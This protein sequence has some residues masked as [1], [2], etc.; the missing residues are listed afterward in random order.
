MAMFDVE[1]LAD[2]FWKDG[3]LYFPRFFETAQMTHLDAI[4]LE[5]FGHMP[6]WAHDDEFIEKSGAEIVPWFPQKEGITDFDIIEADDRLKAVTRAVLGDGWQAL[7][8]MSMFS[9][10]GTQGQAWH[11]DCPPEH[12]E[13]FNLNRLVYTAD[14]PEGLGGEIVLVPGSHKIGELRLGLVQ[15]DVDGQVK[16]MP[17][18]GD[19]I[20]LHGHCWHRVLPVHTTHRVSTNFRAAPQGV[21]EDVTDICVYGNM[22]YK[23]STAEVIMERQG[24]RRL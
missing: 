23:F 18:K 21:P 7:Y 5:H 10:P 20:I 14:R 8:C 3:Y 4:I 16:I 9:K 17:G 15:Q 1:N 22:R 12:T 13:N 19:L 2:R 24:D 11:Q 6:D